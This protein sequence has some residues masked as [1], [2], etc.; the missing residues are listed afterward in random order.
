MATPKAKTLNNMMTG[1]IRNSLKEYSIPNQYMTMKNIIN[2]RLRLNSSLIVS[3]S[4]KKI[5]GTLMDLIM[6]VEL[7]MLPID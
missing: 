2:V 3:D 1:I 7:M 6:P 4:G 5:T